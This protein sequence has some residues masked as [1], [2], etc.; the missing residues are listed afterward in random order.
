MLSSSFDQFNLLSDL[1]SGVAMDLAMELAL[2]LALDLGGCI[3]SS[4]STSIVSLFFYPICA[5][6]KLPVGDGVP[7]EH[8]SISDMVEWHIGPPTK[9]K[10]SGR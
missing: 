7:L 9:W 5:A 8:P 4:S 6:A 1:V 3:V 10:F 2:D